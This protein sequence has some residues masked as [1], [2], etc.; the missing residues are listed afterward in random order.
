MSGLV[1]VY[2]CSWVSLPEEAACYFVVPW[3]PSARLQVA[4]QRPVDRAAMRNALGLTLRSL[5]SARMC[6]KSLPCKD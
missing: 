3:V 6:L 4:A 2:R 1:C 5:R